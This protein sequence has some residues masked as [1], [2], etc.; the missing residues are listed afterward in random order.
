ME[1]FY[2]MKK[3]D[4]I[5]IKKLEEEFNQKKKD[6]EDT[7]DKL[8][9]TYDP[10]IKNK[11]NLKKD[12]LEREM[13]EK[14]DEIEKLKSSTSYKDV[15]EKPISPYLTILCN[16]TEQKSQIEEEY[17][18]F[19]QQ[20]SYRSLVFVVHGD[21]KQSHESFLIRMQEFILPKSIE[22]ISYRFRKHFLEWPLKF[23][24]LRNR[25]LKNLYENIFKNT[26]VSHD[27]I[28]DYFIQSSSEELIFYTVITTKN[29]Q[30]QGFKI[31]DELLNFWQWLYNENIIEKQV[32]ICVLI[33]YKNDGKKINIIIEWIK[34]IFNFK[35]HHIT[36]KKIYAHLKSINRDNKFN[37]LLII[38]V[39]ELNSITIQDVNNW[40]HREIIDFIDKTKINKLNRKINQIFHDWKKQNSSESIPMMELEEH[41]SKL[42]EELT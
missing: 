16:R 3:A 24:N 1:I 37:D 12:R 6:Y 29:W 17:K 23:D 8:N 30:E 33:K 40:T 21:E 35:S 26:D 7:C 36:N 15:T 22:S 19:K 25:L 18:K 38:S 34:S 9:E 42:L 10:E 20:N 27:K 4:N 32:I 28:K 41:L 5:R 31:L 14:E 13:Q 39:E 2:N 11:L